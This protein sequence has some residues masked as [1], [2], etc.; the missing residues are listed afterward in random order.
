MT[1]KAS[2]PETGGQFGLIE[3][4][5]PPG[6]APP[7]HVHHREDEAFYLLDGEGA[8]FCGDRSWNATAGTFLFFPKGIEHGFRID[9]ETPARLPQWNF[10]AGLERM[11]MEA[12]EPVVD[13]TQP[14]V[15]P[16][17]VDRLVALLS[18]YGV[19]LRPTPAGD[20]RSPRRSASR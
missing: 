8:F 7:P 20:E 6:F 13:S 3:Q 4:E 9:G 11:F 10:P 17:D 2:G 15:P 14:A 19:A 12:G 16:A 18:H 5:L 1:L